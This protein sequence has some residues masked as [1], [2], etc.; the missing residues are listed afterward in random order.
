MLYRFEGWI[1]Q[2]TELLEPFVVFLEDVWEE[3][4]YVLGMNLS[5]LSRRNNIEQLSQNITQ[6]VE[7]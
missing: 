5:F 2:E 4:S 1:Y 6:S 3:L 7:F